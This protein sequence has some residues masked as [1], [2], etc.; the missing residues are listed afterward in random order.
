MACP[1]EQEVPSL[2]EDPGDMSPAAMLTEEVPILRPDHDVRSSLWIVASRELGCF[3]QELFS[4]PFH[5]PPFVQAL[6]FLWEPFFFPE[7]SVFLPLHS[8][9]CIDWFCSIELSAVM[10]I[11]ICAVQ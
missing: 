9:D 8:S 5:F 4:L 11:Y 2:V 6:P 10:E 7:A 1:P 3:I